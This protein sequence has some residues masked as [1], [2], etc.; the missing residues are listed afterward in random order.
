MNLILQANSDINEEVILFSTH[1]SNL[2]Q[3]VC[4][5][6]LI[7][8]CFQKAGQEQQ[9]ERVNLL[10]TEKYPILYTFSPLI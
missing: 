2:T 5:S 9:E 6:I 10:I 3:I 1:S 8:E 7:E 4:Y